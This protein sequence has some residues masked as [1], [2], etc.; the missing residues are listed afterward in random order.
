MAKVTPR[1]PSHRDGLAAPPRNARPDITD[2]RADETEQTQVKQ[3]RRARQRVA[4]DTAARAQARKRLFI[5]LGGAV[6][7]VAILVVGIVLIVS[8][9]G[10]N[11]V[12]IGMS[13]PS[14]GSASHVPDGSV[15][16]Y[17]HYPPASGH[18]YASPAPPGFST[19][20]IPEGNWVHSL[21]HGYVVILYKPSASGAPSE[22]QLRDIM[23]TFPNAQSKDLFDHCRNGVGHASKIAGGIFLSASAVPIRPRCGSRCHPS[24]MVDDL[25]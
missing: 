18:H 15:L 14:E 16:T 9:Q 24:K 11:A 22:A 7:G 17:K 3:V 23:A 2:A 1:T 6:L 19:T 8:H 21:E 4:R 20:A 13:I 25:F 12:S 5:R 10:A